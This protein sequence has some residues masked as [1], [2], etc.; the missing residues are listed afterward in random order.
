[1]NTKQG[2]NDTE[3]GL[4]EIRSRLDL[5][6]DYIRDSTEDINRYVAE[7]NKLLVESGENL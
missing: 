6:T 1:M 5:L 2:D 4:N 3:K 7:I